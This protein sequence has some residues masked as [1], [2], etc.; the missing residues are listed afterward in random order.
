[1]SKSK[2]QKKK[3]PMEKILKR[4][5]KLWNPYVVHQRRVPAYT[6][7]YKKRVRATTHSKL[8]RAGYRKY[9]K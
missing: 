2:K 6:S 8:H 4:I 1:M 9:F 3:I 5:M 7:K